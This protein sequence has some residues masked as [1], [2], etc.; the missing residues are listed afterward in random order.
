MAKLK[1]IAAGTRAVRRVPLPRVNLRCPLLPDL[2]E[3]AAQREADHAAHKDSPG[4]DAQIDVGLRVLLGNEYS[5]VL[6]GARDYATARGSKDP[7]PGDPLYDYGE[8]IHR[9]LVA[10]V[11]PDSDPRKPE[12]FFASVDEMLASE[13]LGRDGIIMLAEQQQNWQD[14]C[15]PQALKLTP[16]ELIDWVGKAAA[17]DE[18]SLLFFERLRPGMQWILLRTM[19][20]LLASSPMGKSL[21]GSTTEPS[22]PASPNGPG[23]S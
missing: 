16:D 2:P 19:A 9:V 15:S 7:K 1:D 5:A 14:L 6:E 17:A 4:P 22:T 8:M 12:P 21:F 23:E 11:D 20:T 13:H 18:S 10:A 3:L